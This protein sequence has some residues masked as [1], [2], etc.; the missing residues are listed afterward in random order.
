MARWWYPTSYAIFL[1]IYPYYQQGLLAL[2]KKELFHLIIVM[3]AIWTLPTIV[4]VKLQLG[5][6]NTTCFFMLYAVI[7][8]IRNYE[9]DW[10]KDPKIYRLLTIGGYCLAFISIIC[11]DFLGVKYPSINEY[12]CYYIR[13]NWRLLP[14]LISIGLFLWFS[15]SKIKMN[16]I[17]N[18]VG[19]LT[20]AVYLIHMHPLMISLLFKHL[21]SLEPYIQSHNLMLYV[22]GVTLLIFFGCTLIEQCRKW[23]FSLIGVV[24]NR[25]YR[26]L[27]NC[28]C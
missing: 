20:F 24:S 16:R 7:F 15:N 1:V 18:W 19:G 3:L 23:L 4:P 21:F 12:A 22:V 17:I 5:A 28:F 13:G 11:I 8:Y 10:S 9:P 26:L 27:N 6:N 14:I 2:K 25:I